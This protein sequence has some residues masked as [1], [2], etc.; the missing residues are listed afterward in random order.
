MEPRSEPPRHGPL[1][2][3]E[4][5]EVAVLGDLALVLEVIGWFAPF[6]GAFQA[7]A[8]LPFG[9]LAS[10]H[11]LRA[12]VISAISAA[13][14]AFLVGGLGIVLE[15]GLAATIGTAV[16]T[17]FRRGW[18]SGTAVAASLLVAGVPIAAVTDLIDWISPGFRKL[19]F[20]QVQLLW[21]DVRRALD[22]LGMTKAASTGTHALATAI[23]LWW[24]TL[25]VAELA[26]VLVVA[27]VCLR[28][29]PFLSAVAAKSRDPDTGAVSEDEERGLPVAPVPLE[30]RGVA[31]RYP[32]SVVDAVVGV[33]LLVEPGHFLALV[34]PNGSGKSTLVRLAAGRIAPTRGALQRAG[35]A[36]YGEVGGI[37]MVFQRPE[38]QVLGVRVRDDVWWGL[39]PAERPDVVPLLAMV[40]LEGLAERE[41]SSLS[42]GQLQRLAIAAALAR[43]PRLL[44]SDE[45]TA[46]LDAGGR[47]EV[48]GLLERLRSSGLTVI[49]VTH[50]RSET[51]SA[52]AV[53]ALEHGRI[54]SRGPPS[55]EP[56]EPE[57]PLGMR[58][59]ADGF[60]L[61]NLRGVGYEYAA[62]TPWAHTALHGVDLDLATG[63]GVVITGENGSGK[64]TLAWI[65]GGLLVPTKGSATLG[66]RPID[67]V[68]A[69]VGVAFQHARLQLLRPTVLDDVT[70][71]GDEGAARLALL[72]VGIDPF[73]MGQRKVDDLSGGEQRRVALAGLLVRRPDLLV[74]DEPYAGLD[75]DARRTLAALLAELRRRHGIATV[76]VSHDLDHADMLGDRLLRLESGVVVG[77]EA[78]LT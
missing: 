61:V 46:M 76:V 25:P 29:R 69:R 58:T 27:I 62:G 59:A 51:R 34:G 35:R 33:D 2:P 21:R 15:T 7:L 26:A 75:D 72:S 49:H 39:A 30:L 50:R 57:P 28:L 66:G 52:D 55:G 20:A 32:G 43:R 12:C 38:S 8:I 42:G 14:V 73:E 11:R 3:G 71:G 65:L 64:T 40:G 45:S 74:L 37:A 22:G 18:S 23:R 17:G 31:Y 53:A 6:G 47:W 56:E 16:G 77:E 68:P 24:L 19:S 63:E 44:V 41:T 1:R 36:G 54:V 70:L 13:A 60:P 48:V 10:R 67:T 5:A 4:L 9:V 78:T